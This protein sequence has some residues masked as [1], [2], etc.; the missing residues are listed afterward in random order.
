MTGKIET[1]NSGIESME[2]TMAFRKAIDE[3]NAKAALPLKEIFGQ[4]FGV[5]TGNEN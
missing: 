4:F 1:F 3:M 2:Q 5:K